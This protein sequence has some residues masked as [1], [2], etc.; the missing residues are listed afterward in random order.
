MAASATLTGFYRTS[1]ILYQYHPSLRNSRDAIQLQKILCSDALL[2]PNHPLAAQGPNEKGIQAYIGTFQDGQARL[3]FSSAQVEYL[4]YWLH[5]MRLTPSLIPLPFSDCMFLTEDVSNAEPVVFG[6]AGELVAASKKLGRMNQYLLENPLLVGRRLMFERVRKLWGAKQGVWCALQID[7]WE[8]DHTAISD[9]GWS[10]VRWEPE[11]GKEV[12]QRAHLV[13]KENQEYRKTLLQ[14]DRKSEMVTKGTLKRRVTDLFSELRRHGGPV[15]LLS[16]DV[17]GDI[18][19]L[20]SKAFQVP[21]EDYKPN[22]LDSAAGVYMIDVTELFDALTGAAD[23]DRSTLLRLCNHLRINL[24]EGAR[25][26]GID[27]EASLQALRSMA[28]GP[29]LDQQRSLRWPDQTEVHVEF[30]PWED[31]PEHD[32]LEGLIPMVKSTSEE[33]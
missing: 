33:L 23:A 26:A 2:N 5:A 3:L 14:E 24:N 32:D 15:F 10:L 21:L 30:K 6:S 19:Y 16:N 28:S 1:D 13:V 8:V 4:R 17:K 27:A 25:N 18:H 22:M 12:S 7:A 20:R 29:S 11:S 31:N 9:V